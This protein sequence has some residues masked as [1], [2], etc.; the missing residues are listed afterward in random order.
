MGRVIASELGLPAAG[1]GKALALLADGATLPFIA[2]YRK[3]ATGGLDD[4]ALEKIASR[5]GEL[6]ELSA[7][8]QTILDTIARQ[9]QLTPELRA[10]IE[11][12]RTKAEL[13]DLYLPYKPRRRTRAAIARERGLEPLADLLAAQATGPVDRRALALPYVN[14]EVPDVEAAWQGARDIVGERHREG[15][16]RCH[17]ERDRPAGHA[18]KHPNEPQG[19]RGERGAEHEAQRFH[20]PAGPGQGRDGAGEEGDEEV[21]QGEPEPERGEDR[22]G[23]RRAARQGEGDRGAEERRGAGRREQ[24]RKGAGGEVAGV[25]G[26]RPGGG[27]SRPK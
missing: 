15:D 4:V 11:A 6:V 5:H 19:G 18:G 12:A 3:E 26:A 17:E 22:E 16:R 8:R 25:A 21:G 9:D 10:R 7:R 1:V 13:E 14:G 2:R 23:F 20:P 27:A 24:S